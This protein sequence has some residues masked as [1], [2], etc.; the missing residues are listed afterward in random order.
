MISDR[1]NLFS[2]YYRSEI[3]LHECD[4]A[5]HSQVVNLHFVRSVRIALFTLHDPE[6]VNVNILG[7]PT[8]N[9]DRRKNPSFDGMPPLRLWN[10]TTPVDLHHR[11]H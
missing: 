5:F 8:L 9:H 10:G 4:A 7:S 3:N 1:R 11:E 2:Y 6:S